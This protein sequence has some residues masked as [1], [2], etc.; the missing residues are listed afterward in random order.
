VTALV[1]LD[2]ETTGL[3]SDDDIWEFAAV[4][5][6]P[7]GT[8]TELH[9]FLEHS[10]VKCARLPESFR[11]DHE[12]RFPAMTHDGKWHPAVVRKSDAAGQIDEFLQGRPHIIG[13]VPGFDLGHIARLCGEW[14]EDWSPP[15]HYHVIDVENVALGWLNGRDDRVS[16]PYK[17]DDL[18]AACGVT[19][20]GA[21]RHTA[22]GDVRWVMRW[23]DAMTTAGAA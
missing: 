7:D 9:L 1:F 5:R 22:L 17:S 16:P 11:L 10:P 14:F 15:W 8:E 23:W 13:A 12:D 18:A 6:E 4:R 19:P 20:A 2:T 21:E 3:S